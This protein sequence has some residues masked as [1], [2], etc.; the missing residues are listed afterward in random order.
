MK[1][2]GHLAG[3]ASLALVVTA[4]VPGGA[5][6]PAP[7]PALLTQYCITCHNQRLKTAGL[8]LDAMDFDQVAKDAATWEKVARKIRTGMMPPSG[9]RRPERSV[10]DGFAATLEARLDR[11][12]P[13]G[14]NLDAPALHRL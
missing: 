8:M 4:V 5:Q 9:A 12:A 7:K 14:A 11:A 13:A 6:A 1:P 3:A 2:F 10:L